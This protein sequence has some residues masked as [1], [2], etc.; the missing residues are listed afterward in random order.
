MLH[1]FAVRNLT[2]TKDDCAER[3]RDRGTA[4]VKCK[5]DA[6]D[7][8]RAE[9]PVVEALALRGAPWRAGG[10]AFPT[11]NC[12]VSVSTARRA[13]RTLLAPTM[14][15]AVPVLLSEWRDRSAFAG[16]LVGIAAAAAAR[17]GQRVQVIACRVKVGDGRFHC[18]ELGG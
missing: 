1:R 11:P 6:V 3:R 8:D 17:G 15:V 14:K 9:I 4:S 2:L 12:S 10:V 5:P 7:R 13:I 18:G 16:G